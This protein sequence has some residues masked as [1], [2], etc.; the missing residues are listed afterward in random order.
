MSTL[1]KSLLAI[2]FLLTTPPVAYA[3]YCG[4]GNN[5]SE[6]CESQ[7]G[8]S[9]TN[10]ISNSGSRQTENAIESIGNYLQQRDDEAKVRERA[11]QLRNDQ[12]YEQQK[13]QRQSEGQRNFDSF[14]TEVNSMPENNWRNRASGGSSKADCDCRK[15]VG[16]CKATITLLK[17][18]STGTD[19]KILSSEQSCSKVSYYIDRTPYLTV[20][21]NSNSAT[22]HTAGLTKVNKSSFLI[23]KCEICSKGQ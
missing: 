9:S 6:V 20:L 2:S 1:K 7:G 22:E 21:N 5:V 10:S 4:P 11:E 13:Q 15:T 18:G 23:E 19:Y 16:L 3:I 8:S 14:E 12:E 17:K